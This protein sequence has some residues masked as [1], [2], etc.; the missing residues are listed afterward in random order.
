MKLRAIIFDIYKTLLDVGPP[1]PDA[2]ERW[3]NLQTTTFG[4][5]NTI[6]PGRI[7]GFV[8]KNYRARTCLGAS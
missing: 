5:R 7:R 6:D 2:N 4:R 3:K 1:P 8:Q